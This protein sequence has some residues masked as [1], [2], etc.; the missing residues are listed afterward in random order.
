MLIAIVALLFLALIQ[1]L[2]SP[3]P[4]LLR[5]VIAF[6]EILRA[7]KST[8]ATIVDRK[9][10]LKVFGRDL[11]L[12]QPCGVNNTD[13]TIP[14]TCTSGLGKH[15]RQNLLVID[16]YENT[17]GSSESTVFVSEGDYT[18]HKFPPPNCYDPNGVYKC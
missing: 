18:R 3:Q 7:D 6:Q 5:N 12:L 11:S 9:G 1:Y 15:Q 16:V 10:D 17:P 2:T 14:D 8:G 13:T 4:P